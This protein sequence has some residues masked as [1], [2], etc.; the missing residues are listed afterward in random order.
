MKIE[1][2]LAEYDALAQ[3]LDE[4]DSNWID[5]LFQQ[6]PLELMNAPYWPILVPPKTVEPEP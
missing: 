6:V 2:Q 4:A 1:Q 3:S 5:W